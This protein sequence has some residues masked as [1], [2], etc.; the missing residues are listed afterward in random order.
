VQL[1]ID[2]DVTAMPVTRA[3]AARLNQPA[4]TVDG[5]EQVTAAIRSAPD[6]IVAAKQL[7]YLTRNR[8]AFIRACPGTRSY[9][10]CDYM[11]LHIGTFCRMDCTYCVLQ[12]YFHPPV[13]QFFVNREDMLRELDRYLDTGPERR[14]GTG[15]Y[16]DSLIWELWTDTAQ[17]LVPRFAAQDRCVLE[18]KTK[19]QAVE[20]LAGLDHRGRTIVAW[21][22]NTERAVREQERGTA[23]LAARLQA[24]ARCAAWGYPLAFHFDPLLIYDGCE[25]EYEAVV[26]RL[27]DTLPA[28]S[29]VWISLGSLRFMPALKPIVARRF[30]RSDIIYGEFVPGLDGKL[31]YFKP[32]RIELFRR[33]AAAIRARAP[34]TTVYLCMEDDEVWQRALGFTPDQRGGLPRMLDRAAVRHCGLAA[35]A[36]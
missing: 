6:P 34:D 28:A 32:L 22:L 18:L 20:T 7:L 19:T 23:S 11:I 12:A 31:R 21:S 30:P 27:F 36:R 2:R 5:I 14:I 4:T 29:V 3:I 17:V 15:E 33:V 35:Q 8:G 13:M 24:A 1:F 9:R 26:H 25:Q 10:C 16:T